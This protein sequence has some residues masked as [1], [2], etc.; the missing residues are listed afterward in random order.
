MHQNIL[1]RSWYSLVLW[2]YNTSIIILS[3]ALANNNIVADQD[4]FHSSSEFL[5]YKWSCH[6]ITLENRNYK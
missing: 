2:L 1:L 4:I 3:S 6:N 5:I